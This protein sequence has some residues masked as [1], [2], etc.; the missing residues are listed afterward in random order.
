MRA[1]CTT[2]LELLSPSDELSSVPCGHVF[3]TQ[4]ILQWLETGK[5]N[6]PQCRTSCRERELRRIYMNEAMDATLTQGG[7]GPD[8]SALQ[9]KIDSLAF[10]VRCVNTDKKKL[11]E[12]RDSLKAKN[13][14]LT[15]EV[16][17]SERLRNEEREA[18]QDMKSKMRYLQAEKVK[19]KKAR[20]EADELRDKLVLYKAVDEMVRGSM[21]DV[22]NQLHNIGDFSKTSR[23][24][25]VVIV[26]LKRELTAQR[27]ERADLKAEARQRVT[28]VAELRLKLSGHAREVTELA[29]ENRMLRSD[30]RHCEEERDGLK[31]RV[32]K[33]EEAL[34][35][36]TGET[37]FSAAFKRMVRE[38]PAPRPS[39]FDSEGES[40]AQ[41]NEDDDSPYLKVKSHSLVGLNRRK[42]SPCK[43]ATNIDTFNIMK[44]SRLGQSSSGSSGLVLSSFS[45]QQQPP[46][47]VKR[48]NSELH[49]DGLGGHSKSDA[50]PVKSRDAFKLGRKPKGV[51]RPKAPGPVHV[52]AKQEKSLQTMEM[53]FSVLDTP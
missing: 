31:S 17:T 48:T 51:S 20:E 50:F 19:A 41:N 24:L 53:F 40:S 1:S 45:Q 37:K 5:S 25:S 7:S 26:G 6:C 43:D 8:T 29:Q 10:E 36:P 30:L 22:N 2:C 11:S 49:Y 9:N 28:T 33:L 27:E 42:R 15:E 23:E 21:A 12:E 39:D 38:S 34:S 44:K 14:G 18:V 32:R 35:S 4:C 16:R 13:L 52:S 47:Q 3:H 46:G